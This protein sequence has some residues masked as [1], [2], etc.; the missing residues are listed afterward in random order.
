MAHSSDGRSIL[1]GGADRMARLW[2]APTGRPIGPPLA[3]PGSVDS[4]AFSPDGKIILIGCRDQPARLW[5]AATGQQIGQTMWHPYHSGAV[6]FSPDGRFLL[7]CGSE[8]VSRLWDVPAPLPDDAPRLA[9]W[10]EAAT[11][12]ELDERGSVRALDRDAWQERRRRLEQLGGPPPDPA[13]RLDPMIFGDETA[14][15]GD[16]FAERGLWDQAEVSSSRGRPRPPL[17]AQ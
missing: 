4:V 10:V 17:D 3:H 6:A 8:T 14:A 12:L 9:A 11:G 7:T 16:A 15:R 2:E 13:P 1:T 5:D